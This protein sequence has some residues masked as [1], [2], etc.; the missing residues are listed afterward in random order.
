MGE[1]FPPF[2][3]GYVAKDSSLTVREGS[4]VKDL[5]SERERQGEIGPT[6]PPIS[7]NNG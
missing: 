4:P 3:S 6:V 7:R 5:L 1:S 2:K